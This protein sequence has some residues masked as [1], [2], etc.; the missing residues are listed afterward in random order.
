MST[1]EDPSPSAAVA[2]QWSEAEERA[3]AAGV[4]PPHVELRDGPRR[5]TALHAAS[6]PGCRVQA[7][8]AAS[9]RLL[10]ETRLHALQGGSHHSKYSNAVQ[11]RLVGGR[12]AVFGKESSGRYVEVLDTATGAQLYHQAVETPP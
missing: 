3:S 10:W 6:A 12:L 11:L 1:N 4:V 2:W 8:E 7:H 9:G 5:Y